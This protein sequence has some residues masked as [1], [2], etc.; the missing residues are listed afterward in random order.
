[1]DVVEV[2]IDEDSQP[3]LVS[4]IGLYDPDMYLKVRIE[5]AYDESISSVYYEDGK[6][7][8]EELVNE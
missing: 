8:W 4:I 3:W 1:L 5:S 6:P 7:I 2:R